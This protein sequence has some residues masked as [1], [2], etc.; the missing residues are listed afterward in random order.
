MPHVVWSSCWIEQ[1][2]LIVFHCAGYMCPCVLLQILGSLEVFRA[3]FADI[4]LQRYVHTE[5]GCDVVSLDSGSL[6]IIPSAA[7]GEVFVAL[8]ADMEIAKMVVEQSGVVELGGT[9]FPFAHELF[10]CC[11]VFRVFFFVLVFLVLSVVIIF[12]LVFRFYLF[13]LAAGRIFGLPR[14]CGHAARQ[15]RRICDV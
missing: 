7:Q 14:D 4:R 8:A 13:F 12:G 15:R 3:R 10:V 5:M 2:A 11:G 6:T 1:I 9:I